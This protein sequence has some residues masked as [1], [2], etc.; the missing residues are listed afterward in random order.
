[1]QIE[2][3][4]GTQ[5]RAAAGYS[6]ETL[7]VPEECSVASALAQLLMSNVKL[8]PWIETSGLA[9]PGLLVFVNDQSPGDLKLTRLKP[10][11]HVALMAMV[12]GG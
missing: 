1:M 3:E 12:S 11:D 9:R 7:D 5:V 10:H 2:I 8:A 4:Y 6:R